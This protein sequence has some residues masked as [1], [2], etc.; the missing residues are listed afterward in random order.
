MPE[1]KQEPRAR[2]SEWKPDPASRCQRVA[3]S[4]DPE[5]GWAKPNGTIG[6]DIPE[7]GVNEP[8]PG[9]LSR[10]EWICWHVDH[11]PPL[12]PSKKAD[13]AAILAPVLQAYRRRPPGDSPAAPCGPA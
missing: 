9:G 2:K 3:P 6:C 5:R 11:A 10:E 7:H 1:D 8:S 13:L 4:L 12:S